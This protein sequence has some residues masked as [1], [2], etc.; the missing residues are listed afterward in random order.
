ML[1]WR[2][3]NVMGFY[4]GKIKKN[5]YLQW[6][7]VTVDSAYKIASAF[8]EAEIQDH[9]GKPS[10]RVKKKIFATLWVTEKRVVVKLKPEDQSVFCKYDSKTFFPATGAWG[11]QG[12]TNIE[13]K[14]VHKDM[15]KD[16]ITLS[17]MN[18]APKKLVE[19][20]ML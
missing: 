16:A 12:W 8:P 19:N 2:D 5:Y 18:V 14:H 15:L 17:W 13:L 9:F 20:K 7:M 6:I 4:K 3:F 1:A 10:F 11:R